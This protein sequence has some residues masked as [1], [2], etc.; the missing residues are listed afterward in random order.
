MKRTLRITKKLT[1]LAGMMLAL[2][3]VA[4]ADGFDPIETRKSGMDLVSVTFANIKSV[5]TTNG[6]VKTLEPS[7]KAI[8]RFAL[9]YPTLFPAGSGTENTKAGPTIWSDSAGFK[10]IATNLANAADALATAAKAGDATASAA[11][12]KEMGEACGACHKDYRLK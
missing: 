4:H 9:V 5:V 3:A 1:L 7:A 2:G 10:K 12:Y 6:D 8:K 11:A